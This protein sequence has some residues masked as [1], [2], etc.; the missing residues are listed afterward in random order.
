MRFK[1]EQSCTATTAYAFFGVHRESFT[2]V[3]IPLSTNG[4]M[5]CSKTMLTDSG[6]AASP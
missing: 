6:N 2:F 4:L 5:A 3:S 1:N